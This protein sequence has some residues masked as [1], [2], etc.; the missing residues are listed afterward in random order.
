MTYLFVLL[1]LAAFALVHDVLNVREGRTVSYWGSYLILVSVAGLRYKVGGDTY[2]YMY[3]H[4]FLPNLGSLFSVDVGSE[5][6]QPLWLIFS[7]AAK[8]IADDF[9]ILQFLHAITVN[10][11]IFKFVWNNT[12]FRHTGILLY[13][14][15]LFPYF[16]FEILRESLAICCFLVSIRY[17]ASNNLIRYYFLTTL[18][19]LFHFSAVFLFLLPFIKKFKLKVTGLLILFLMSALLNPVVMAAM[20]STIAAQLVGFAIGGYESYSYTFFGLISI[21]IYYLLVPLVLTWVTQ[22][23]LKVCTQYA[24]VARNGLVV[25]ACIPLFFIFYRFFNYFSVLYLLMACETIH[26]IAREKM[27]RNIK[28]IVLPFLFCLTVIFYAGKYFQDTSY[29]AES[30]RWY[31]RWYPYHSI[32]D[33]VSLPLREQMIESQNRGGH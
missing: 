25:A 19:F 13:S 7:A 6:L 2:N 3:M 1:T 4:E 11:I 5:K 17:Y 9:Y 24:G 32:F 20:N 27:F 10:A 26:G 21:L 18:A 12:R 23:K 16:N 31:N 33:P 15:S 22:N 30:S 14:F 8:S 28:L 29:L